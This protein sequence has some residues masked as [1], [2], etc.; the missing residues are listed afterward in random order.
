M[1]KLLKGQPVA[2]VIKEKIMKDVTVWKS[3]GHTPRMAALLVEGDTA[4]EFYAHAKK[5]MAAKLGIEFE[6]STFPEGVSEQAILD[7]IKALNRDPAVHGIMLELPLPSHISQDLV[8]EAVSPAKDVD[9]LTRYNRHANVTGLP[10]LYPA[11]PIACVKLVEHYGYTVS[12]KHVALIGCGKTVGMPLFHLLVRKNAT[13]TACHA[14]TKDLSVH[15]SQAEIAF[16]AVGVAGLIQSNMVHPDLIIVDAGI[17]ETADHRIV[18]DVAPEAAS[19]ALA[20]SPTPGGVGTVT[21]VQLFA[22]LMDAMALQLNDR[23]ES[24]VRLSRQHS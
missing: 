19:V 16:V 23:K 3:Q 6:L 8:I 11:T 24:A 21:T 7:T 12:G 10:G 22:N 14:G 15:L 2:E 1:T 13:V 4:S 17:N 18:G 9:G 20:L 5:R